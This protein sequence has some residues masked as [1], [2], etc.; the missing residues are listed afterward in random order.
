MIYTP[1]SKT[2]HLLGQY[3]TSITNDIAQSIRNTDALSIWVYLQ[4]QS[5]SKNYRIRAKHL[6]EHF[7]LG[8]T[9]YLRAMKILRE[10]DLIRYEIKRDATGR[11][12]DNIIHCSG[13]PF[14]TLDA[15]NS[16]LKAFKDKASTGNPENTVFGGSTETLKTGCSAK[17]LKIGTKANKHK[18]STE[19]LKTGCSDEN[20]LPNTLFSGVVN[21]SNISL[22]EKSVDNF[23]VMPEARVSI[24]LRNLGFR[25]FRPGDKRL[26]AALSNGITA[27]EIIEIAEQIDD[28]DKKHLGYVIGVIEGQRK[29]AI[30]LDEKLKKNPLPNKKIN[31]KSAYLEA[32]EQSRKRV[33]GKDVWSHP[34][35]FWAYK[36]IGGDLNRFTEREI[37]PRWINA[38]DEAETGLKN[39]SLSATIPPFLKN[40]PKLEEKEAVSNENLRPASEIIEELNRK[41]KIKTA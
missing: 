22:N 9:R 39:G 3:S 14:Y 40:K 30:K 31:A 38:L 8:E 10:S 34:A 2:I 35:I 26:E 18:A 19:T 41:Y 32:I 28:M 11:V 5:N 1:D 25:F 12:V 27:D 37:F 36:T 29:D 23:E 33:D 17:Y 4:T 21:I 13:F 20:P 6:Q 7:E 15:I 16:G 24:A